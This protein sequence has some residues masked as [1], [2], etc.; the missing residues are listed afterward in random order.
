MVVG[1]FHQKQMPFPYIYCKN[2]LS[3]TCRSDNNVGVLSCK[4]AARSPLQKLQTQKARGEF[5]GT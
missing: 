5:T 1:M 4:R 2:V 3:C